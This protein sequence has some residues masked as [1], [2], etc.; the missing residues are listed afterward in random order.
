MTNDE[1]MTKLECRRGW[2]NRISSFGLVS[3]FVI[4]ISSFFSL[5]I[6]A[7]RALVGRA[8]K[9]R[10]SGFQ[11][12][13]LTGRMPVTLCHQPHAVSFSSS[14]VVVD[15]RAR[16]RMH[17][18]DSHIRRGGAGVSAG[19]GRTR[20]S[21]AKSRG[22]ISH[23]QICRYQFHARH[24]V[25]GRGHNCFCPGRRETSN[26]CP[27]AN[28]ISGNG[29]WKV[30]TISWRASSGASLCAKHFGFSRPYSSSFYS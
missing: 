5:V 17:A 1:G 3:S 28:R 12:E 16:L 29:W 26:R 18:G 11:P 6:A 24:L 23:R 19:E 25:G 8:A 21:S 15:L 4:R 2:Q 20:S 10:S 30:C 27:T 14:F 7:K 13:R 9:L 22:V